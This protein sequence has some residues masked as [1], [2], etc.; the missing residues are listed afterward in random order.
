M[1]G[2]KRSPTGH[3]DQETEITLTTSP[4]LKNLAREWRNLESRA[5]AFSFFQSW[6]WQSCLV[7]ERFPQP[8]LVRAVSAGRTIGLA[9]FNRLGS[10]LH[11]AESG[12]ID[13]DAIYIEH[14]APLVAAD[15][16]QEI[17]GHMIAAC[18]QYPGVRH[19]VLSGTRL[20]IPTSVT[21]G[22][23]IKQKNQT[24]PFF[25]IF[26][27]SQNSNTFI[28][29]RSRNTRSQIRRSI[30]YFSKI[31]PL[32]L[33]RPES[34]KQ[35]LICLADMIELHTENWRRRGCAGAFANTFMH[36]FHKELILLS[37]QRNEID[38]I[39]VLAGTKTIGILYN[40]IHNGVIY[41]YQSGFAS[42]PGVRDARPGLVSHALAI[43]E[44]QKSGFSRYDFLAGDARY[45]RSLANNQTTLTWSTMVRSDFLG[46]MQVGVQTLLAGFRKNVVS[47]FSSGLKI[48]NEHQ[49][50]LQAIQDQ[51]SSRTRVG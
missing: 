43:E 26:Q 37:Y 47:A 34:D 12:R 20:N 11:L 33:V 4:D 25:D 16:P 31:G 3:G 19:L 39:R 50:P 18:W 38:F 8:I 10:T 40:F 35:A 5:G 22:L 17:A 23:I 32:M 49:Q 46:R 44:A 51:T 24:A 41:A 9:L 7:T 14:N 42:F 45:K 48:G 2:N 13:F 30:K 1:E 21:G 15:A 6:T 36:R 29:S 28:E 27:I